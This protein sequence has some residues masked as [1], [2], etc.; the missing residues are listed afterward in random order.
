MNKVQPTLYSPHPPEA[1]TRPDNDIDTPGLC[2]VGLEFCAPERR[3]AW[4]LYWLSDPAVDNFLLA[5][6]EWACSKGI[7]F[8]LMSACLQAMQQDL[9]GVPMKAL[10]SEGTAGEFA[11]HLRRHPHKHLAPHKLRGETWLM[12][13]GERAANA[14]GA[15]ILHGNLY[16]V[17]F[18][19]KPGLVTDATVEPISATIMP[20][21][22]RMKM[23]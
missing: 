15:L 1:Y 22:L 4:N 17:N 21:A 14:R 3:A 9:G 11:E 19:R 13:V 5:E 23:Q 6:A 2:G 7:D 18:T 10:L 16:N 8:D 20:L 12:T